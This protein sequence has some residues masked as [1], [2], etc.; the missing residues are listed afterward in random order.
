M[1]TYVDLMDGA[2]TDETGH[3]RPISRLFTSGVSLDYQSTSLAVSQRGAGANMSVDVA[4]GDA[5]FATV[6]GNSSYWGFNDAV[7][8]VTIDAASVVNPRIDVVVIYIDSANGSGNNSPNSM[9]F[10]V[11]KGTPSATP[12]AM[13]D[14]AIQTAIGPTK[15][16]LKLARV[17][18]GTSVTQIT[19]AVITDLRTPIIANSKLDVFTVESNTI[20]DNA[21][22]TDKIASGAVETAKIKDDNV[23]YTKVAPGFPVQ[24]AMENFSA[25]ATGST[26]MPDD[27]TIPQITEGN[28]FMTI[29]FTPKSATNLLLIEA[30]A[31]FS[32][33]TAAPNLM[34]ALFK[35]PTADAIAASNVY[36]PTATGPVQVNLGHKMVAG[37]TSAITFSFRAG[38]GS[39]GTMTFNGQSTLGKFGAATSSFMKI[40]EIKA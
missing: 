22:T 15:P 26:I 13:S 9:K 10:Y 28:E 24:M 20:Q 1:A 25:A 34:Y 4:V 23:T 27:D 32:Y 30:T 6:S 16:F 21:V 2:W 12:V 5:H 31:N 29:T 35:N 3:H 39:A 17:S 37:T 19:N 36:Q 33:S 8:N 38:G 7:A 18:V 40:T 14:S 11:A